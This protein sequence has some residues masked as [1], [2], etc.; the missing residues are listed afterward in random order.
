MTPGNQPPEYP[1]GITAASPTPL[2]SVQPV[3]AGPK[4]KNPPRISIVT[5]NYNYAHFLDGTLRS[6]L[7]QNYPNLEYIVVDDGSTDHSMDVIRRY[8]NRLAHWET[9]PNRGQYKA[10]THGFTKATGDIFGWLNS[11]DMY[12]PWTLWVVAGIFERFPEVEWISTLRPG[13]WDRSG[14]CLG[15]SRIRGFSKAAFL[16]GANLPPA[17]HLKTLIRAQNRICIQQESTFWRRSLWDRAGGYVSHEHGSAGDFELWCRFYRHAE[18]H[19]VNVP[20]AGFRFQNQQ[21]TTQAQKYA[22]FCSPV[23]EIF[24]NE[25]CWRPSLARQIG[26]RIRP[27]QIPILRR[28]VHKPFA[29]VGKRISR[30]KID[31]ADAAWISA[32]HRFHW[33]GTRL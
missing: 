16:D 23:L 20:L 5:P 4:L 27:W 30:T 17:G 28:F 13:F 10:I 24:R 22:D 19:G 2:V 26:H 9:G 25:V 14:F 31:T 33:S 1:D 29:Y 11:D 8:A 32:P 6:V 3:W 15:F 21:Q 18:L 12:F 7:D